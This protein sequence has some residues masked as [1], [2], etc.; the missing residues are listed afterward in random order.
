MKIYTNAQLLKKTV[1]KCFYY[2]RLICEY[3]EYL[4]VKWRIPEQYPTIN[5]L[6]ITKIGSVLIFAPHSD[7]EWIGNSQILLNNTHSEI[8]Y[9]CFYGENQTLEN[10]KTRDKE[11]ADLADR[12]SVRLYMCNEDRLKHLQNLLNDK[13][14]DTILIPSP[15][16]WHPQHRQTFSIA[17]NLLSIMKNEGCII[18]HVYYYHISVPH[19][20]SNKFYAVLMDRTQ[21]RQ[22]WKIFYDVY[23]SQSFMP[24]ERYG[25][26]ERL[27][28]RGLGY[29]CEL[30]I[31]RSFDEMVSDWIWINEKNE[32]ILNHLKSKIS[33]IYDIRCSVANLFR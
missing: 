23:Q 13:Q 25:L 18:P 5:S 27:D 24:T 15:F 11:I 31:L 6:D 7:D 2:K 20:V 17:L 12:L 26:Q 1:L 22:K 28:A 32:S 8:A 14:Y 29:A 4:Q 9:M 10:I 33:S 30:Y 21:Q 19:I 3:I 16:D